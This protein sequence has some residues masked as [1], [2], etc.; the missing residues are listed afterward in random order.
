MPHDQIIEV[1]GKKISFS[2]GEIAKQ[3]DGAVIV[4]CGETVVFASAVCA[5][6]V[7]EGQDFFPLSVEYREK[8]YAAGRF[9]GG[10]IKREGKPGDHEVLVCRI[11]DRPLRPLFPKDFLNDVQ[12]II[13]VLATDKKEMAD[14]LAINAASAALSVSAIPFH[15]PVGAVRVGL[16]DGKYILNPTKDEI[17]KS[18]LDLVV[19]GTVKAV[20]MIEGESSNITEDEMLAAIDFAHENIKVICQGQLELK[21]ACGKP[22]MTYTPRAW[23]AELEK[24]ARTRY[25]ADVEALGQVREKKAREVALAASTPLCNSSFIRGSPAVF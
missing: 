19:A 24:A 10:Y 3:A 11:T 9:P 16:I 13:Y 1:G 8:Y 7:K 5:H 18:R 21:K 15:G 22:E 25:T 23:D 14:V 4:S 2:T 12:I 6:S 20:T 17:K